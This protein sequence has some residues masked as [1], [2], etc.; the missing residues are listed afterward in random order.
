MNTS[1]PIWGTNKEF[2]NSHD[3]KFI[4]RKLPKLKQVSYFKI[5]SGGHRQAHNL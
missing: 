3:R 4:L 2:G 1:I 5:L